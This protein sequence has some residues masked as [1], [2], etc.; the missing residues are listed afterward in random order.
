MFPASYAVEMCS[1]Y[2]KK[3]PHNDF[4]F[5]CRAENRKRQQEQELEK[6]SHLPKLCLTK[7]AKGMPPTHSTFLHS[8]SE[9][10]E[11]KDLSSYLTTSRTAFG[12]VGEHVQ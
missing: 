3:Q 6:I 7:E 1:H 10:G 5:L 4:R 2:G 9:R 12:L 8:S 11:I